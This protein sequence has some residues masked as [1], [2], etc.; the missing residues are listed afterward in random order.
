METEMLLHETLL[1][2]VL[3]RG[4]KGNGLWNWTSLS[5]ATRPWAHLTFFHKQF[6]FTNSKQT[7]LFQ[8]RY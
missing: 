4:Q 6:S 2:N 7:T 5:S 8:P 3:F 1:L